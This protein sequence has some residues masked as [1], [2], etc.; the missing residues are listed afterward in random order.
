MDDS[1]TGSTNTAPRSTIN[2][3]VLTVVRSRWHRLLASVCELDFT[4][5]RTGNR[6]ALPV[7]YVGDAS[8]IVIYVAGAATKQWWRNFEHPRPV[9]IR[10]NGITYDGTARIIAQEDPG[11]AEAEEFYHGR[12]PKV[13]I[14]PDAPMIVADVEN[15]R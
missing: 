9:R 4:G 15:T 1:T 5:R 14:A 10:A 13:R 12:F 7:Q 3:L 2:R 11:R 8:H 6:V